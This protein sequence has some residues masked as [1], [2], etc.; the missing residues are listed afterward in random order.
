MDAVRGA[1][2]TIE[3]K[4]IYELVKEKKGAGVGNASCIMELVR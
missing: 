3:Y 4:E 2:A 1:C